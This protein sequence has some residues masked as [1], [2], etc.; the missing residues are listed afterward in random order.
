MPRKS[1]LSSSVTDKLL[2]IYSRFEPS[3]VQRIL[4]IPASTFSRYRQGVFVPSKLSAVRLLQAG[5][6]ADRRE[7]Y[8]LAKKTGLSVNEAR[9]VSSKNRFVALQVINRTRRR[10]RPVGPFKKISEIILPP[11]KPDRTVRPVEK[12]PGVI[13]RIERAIRKTP[14]GDRNEK[15]QYIYDLARKT[16]LTAAE[17]RDIRGWNTEKAEKYLLM[18]EGGAMVMHA[19]AAAEGSR[20]FVENQN[21]RYNRVAEFLAKKHNVKIEYIKR[22]MTINYSLE[23]TVDDWEEYIKEKHGVKL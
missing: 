11:E 21:A 5:R 18:R 2:D 23:R 7:L 8:H 13:K 3:Y 4:G 19:R 12:L 16:G 14:V 6:N 17:S 22:G 20:E 15:R 9:I 10:E 1:S